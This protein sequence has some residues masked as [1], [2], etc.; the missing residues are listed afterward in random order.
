MFPRRVA[1]DSFPFS[2]LPWMRVYVV[3][4]G[5][6]IRLKELPTWTC[7]RGEWRSANVVSFMFDVTQQRALSLEALCCETATQHS[8]KL[9]MPC[10]LSALLTFPPL[11]FLAPPHASQKLP[12]GESET[13]ERCR[14]SYPSDDWIQEG[15]GRVSDRSRS[16]PSH[17]SP[18][19]TASPVSPACAYAL[20]LLL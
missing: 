12:G 17:A 20:R 11:L 1:F 8:Y 7:S 10:Q 9:R 16:C 18:S 2:H 14:S 6:Y 4:C 19:R 13:D 15:G 5:M 3:S